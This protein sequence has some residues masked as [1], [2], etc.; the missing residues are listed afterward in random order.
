[1]A[2]LVRLILLVLC[3]LSP[4]PARAADEAADEA[5]ARPNLIE[6]LY[7]RSTDDLGALWERGTLRVLVPYS[8]TNYFVDDGEA[9]GFEYRL[10]K[11]Y[12]AYLNKTRP[13]DAQGRRVPPMRLIFVPTMFETVFDDLEGGLGSIAAAFLTQTE[14]R[15]H[16]VAFT[17]PYVSGVSEILV[18]G[19]GVEAAAGIHGLSG[20]TVTVARGTTYAEALEQ[21]NR[22][23]QAEG[24]APVTVK[25]VGDGIADE[26]L[27]AL[28]DQGLIEATICDQPIATVWQRV[29]PRLKLHPQVALGTKGR[30]G[31]AVRPGNPQ[32]RASLDA[33]LQ[34]MPPKEIEKIAVDIARRLRTE[35]Q[36]QR[37]TM[38]RY[39]YLLDMVKTEAAAAGIDWRLVAAQIRKESGF[40]PNA[41]SP[42]GAVGLMQLMPETAEELGVTDRRDPL[43]SIRGGI[44]YL[45]KLRDGYFPEEALTPVERWR[46]V[47]A[48]YN[49]GPNR[50]NRIRRNAPPAGID[51]DRYFN[52]VELLVIRQRLAETYFYVRQIEGYYLAYAIKDPP[53]GS[54]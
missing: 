47:F 31:F 21:A 18:T 23:L 27:L 10:L 12:E 39:G 22:Q 45:L 30:I 36:A 9:D 28:V 13:K 25:L 41:V 8:R 34:T 3:V 33:F 7:G 53:Q 1:M 5:A 46:F 29:L 52:S 24:R 37:E 32:L 15:E 51:P 35:E 17:R 44:R 54:E 20:R 19:R 49:A 50:I 2:G 43:Q 6:E 48:G 26:D 42:V 16:R 38:R 14:A 11:K 4:L 40:D